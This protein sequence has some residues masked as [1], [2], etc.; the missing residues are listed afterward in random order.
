M[1]EAA[2]SAFVETRIFPLSEGPRALARWP[3]MGSVRSFRLSTGDSTNLWRRGR[4][5]VENLLKLYVT[6]ADCAGPPTRAWGTS[7]AGQLQLA[8]YRKS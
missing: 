8:A 5:P 6:T 2:S 3:P 4:E 7:L 1:G